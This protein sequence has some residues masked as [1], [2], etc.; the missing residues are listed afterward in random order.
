[1]V[2]GG[3]CSDTGATAFN[4]SYVGTIRSGAF[5]HEQPV[6]MIA[7]KAASDWLRALGTRKQ[8]STTGG[9]MQYS[10]ALLQIR[11]FG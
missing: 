6:R 9:Q 11:A 8:M 2:G 7:R 1:M 4:G 5:G 3:L 10:K